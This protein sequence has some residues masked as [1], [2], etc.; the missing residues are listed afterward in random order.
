MPIDVPQVAQGPSITL[1]AGAAPTRQRPSFADIW[2]AISTEVLAVVIFGY[3]FHELR[4][5]WKFANFPISFW[6]IG[7][8]LGGII[9]FYVIFHLYLAKQSS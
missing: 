2:R 3:L 1:N 7:S 5:F 6:V 8:I 4:V 9:G